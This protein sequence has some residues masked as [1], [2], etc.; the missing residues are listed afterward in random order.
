MAEAHQSLPV[1][2]DV[3]DPDFAKRMLQWAWQV[4]LD[5]HRT[6]A[7]TH[8]TIAISRMLIADADRLL[9]R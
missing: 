3:H 2:F 6:V 9:S 1:D 5:M 8:E 4:Q 7:A